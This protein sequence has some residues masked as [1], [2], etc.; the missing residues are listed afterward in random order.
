MDFDTVSLINN[1]MKA[2]EEYEETPRLIEGEIVH[3]DTESILK[4]SRGKT[5]EY[6]DFITENQFTDFTV[7]REER[8]AGKPIV[9]LVEDPHRPRYLFFEKDLISMRELR[10]AVETLD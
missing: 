2:V 5:K 1:A 3:I 7:M 9:S 6:I 8:F 10:E 4:M